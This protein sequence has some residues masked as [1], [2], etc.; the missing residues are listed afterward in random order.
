M[1][2]SF[3]FS[4]FL[5][6]CLFFGGG[7]FPEFALVENINCFFYDWINYV[8]F[9]FLLFFTLIFNCRLYFIPQ[10]LESL[11]GDLNL[12]SLVTN[13]LWQARIEKYS[14]SESGSAYFQMDH[15]RGKGRGY[16]VVK[17]YMG[18][19]LKCQFFVYLGR[20]KTNF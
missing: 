14:A 12:T 5:L 13:L 1:H 11:L 16:P 10:D 19:E 7:G 18:T 3:L 2:K 4:V 9:L 17:F 15:Q 6:F 8:L 20:I